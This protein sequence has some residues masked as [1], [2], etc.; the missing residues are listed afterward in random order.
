MKK[1]TL[2]LFT[3]C[4]L[5]HVG[6]QAQVVHSTEANFQ[7]M[8]QSMFEPGDALVISNT[9]RML[10]DNGEEASFFMPI[11]LDAVLNVEP[12]GLDLGDY[13][14][15]LHTKF[16]LNFD[17]YAR[18]SINSG[19]VDIDYPVKVNFTVP[20]P[21]TY[22]CDE[23]ITINS[24][25]ELKNPDQYHMDAHAPGAE[26]A[27]GTQLDQGFYFGGQKC[28]V[29]C[30]PFPETDIGTP[31]FKNAN[32]SNYKNYLKTGD[33]DLFRISTSDGLQLPWDLYSFIPNP[34]VPAL[35]L[36]FNTAT[37]PV[38]AER[39]KLEGE[40]DNPFNG[41]DGPDVLTGK[42]LANR[43]DYKF[44]DVE[45][46]P[47]QFQEYFTGVPLTYSA[48]I[49]PFHA[50]ID[51]VSIPYILRTYMDVDLEFDPHIVADINFGQPISWKEYEGGSLLRSGTSQI[52]TN[53]TVGNDL[54]IEYPSNQQ[55]TFS[56]TLKIE[57]NFKTTFELDF[58]QAI[59]IR[60]MYT[61]IEFDMP[62]PLDDINEEFG[63]NE[64]IPLPGFS[65][66]V[67]DKEFS[68]GGFSNIAANPITLTPDMAPPVV[69]T[70]NIVVYIPNA[71]GSVN[72]APQDVVASAVDAN[73]GTV[74]YLSVTPNSF[75]CANLGSNAVDVTLDDSRCNPI[76]KT[77]SVTVADSTRPT[78]TC[79]SFTI[80]L[81][82]NG[83][84]S[85]TSTQVHNSSWDNCGTVNIEG[86]SVSD[87]DCDDLG[88]NS[89]RL[90]VNDGHG[91]T[92]SCLGAITVIDNKPPVLDCQP[93]TAYLDDNGEAFIVLNDVLISSYDNCGTVNVSA[94]SPTEFD[95][96]DIGQVAV[97]IQT[98]DGHGN[99][100]GCS[101]NVEVV[102]IIPPTVECQPKVVVSLNASGTGSITTADAFVSGADNCGIVNQQSIFPNSFTCADIGDVVA[103]LT[104]N[105]GH[106]NTG[107]CNTTVVVVDMIQ[108]TMICRNV[109]LD[110]DANGEATLNPVQMDNGSFDNCTIAVFEVDQSE[111]TCANLGDNLI[112]LTG[113]DQSGNRNECSATV[114]IRDLIIPVSQCKDF[115]INLD[116]NG[117]YLL[118]TASVDDGSYDN[119]YLEQAVA[120]N[121]FNCEDI[122]VHVVTLTNTD[123][124][125][126]ASTCTAS[127]DVRDI[128]PPNAVCA[129]PVI[130]LDETGHGTLEVGQ[131][132]GGSSDACGIAWM[133]ISQREFDC[134]KIQ[135]SARVVKLDMADV[136]GNFNSCLSY[137]TVKD[138]LAPT[139]VC[140]DTTVMLNEEGKVTVYAESL[141]L[142]SYDNCEVWSYLPIATV[143]TIANL[144][145]NDLQIKV[146]DWSQNGSTC[147][148]L[149]TVLDGA[150]IKPEKQKE[151]KQSLKGENRTNPVIQKSFDFDVYP[152]P[153]D[154]EA[155]IVFSL[156]AEKPYSIRAYDMAGR[157]IFSREGRGVIGNNSL[158]IVLTGIAP[159]VYVLDF[160]SEDVNVQKRLVI[161]R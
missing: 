58:E 33:Y 7:A 87:F 118:E 27:V 137:V 146:K 10:A 108:P 39:A 26:F 129:N 6:T 38:I 148:S 24:S 11:D 119:C 14:V 78:I 155:N 133:T 30:D 136:N 112:T 53:F 13:G 141:A 110:L 15:E 20:T 44:L 122:G 9:F 83:M 22:G 138:R 144:G 105:D 100:T 56:P 42:V 16:G 149:V 116:E 158:P 80:F 93:T 126:N 72:I 84:S 74:R 98:N 35:T 46:D 54:K 19:S 69:T 48:D 32:S 52:L 75:E 1:F 29:T 41:I 23:E 131:V 18:Y 61:T 160:T 123:Q 62:D 76:T 64:E 134:S 101:I 130:Y 49:G 17:L 140:K 92:N 68:M 31:S 159:G 28:F 60:V 70:Q 117:Q 43:T 161:Q 96:A 25:W 120:P 139:A 47:I 102:D 73:G 81:D 5:L 65:I 12:L 106:G 154:N 125:S 36:P 79:N 151:I 91:N 114:T 104:V 115:V 143:Y 82:D 55:V 97:S 90:T 109:V 142:N 95:C 89:T 34:G 45:F 4:L 150:P 135:G 59:G 77:A 85:I 124:S 63:I 57:N 128:T 132:D 147:I 103:T 21:S 50:S 66:P 37:I 111:F 86:L 145:E 113:I 121:Q 3:I 94:F 153:T 8:D 127:V 67:Y 107:T 88:N 40:L 99:N 156:D 152:N 51:L 157:L 71:G 2:L